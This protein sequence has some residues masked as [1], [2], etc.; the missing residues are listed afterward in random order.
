MSVLQPCPLHVPLMSSPTPLRACRT[1]MQRWTSAFLYEIGVV[2][3]LACVFAVGYSEPFSSAQ[4]HAFTVCL[5]NL[6]YNMSIEAQ[7]VR[8]PCS[9]KLSMP[10][11]GVG[12][13]VEYPLM[14]LESGLAPLADLSNSTA[15]LNNCIVPGSGPTAAK[16]Y[17]NG[18]LVCCLI[19]VPFW[20]AS[21]QWLFDADSRDSAGLDQP[22]AYKHTVLGSRRLTAA[23]V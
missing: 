22:C 9:F 11:A 18:R 1:M 19:P 23:R 10:F 17:Y 13:K 16:R 3:F 20:R 21:D 6:I 12:G 15:L 8:K 7:C 14:A 2:V 4:A 5:C